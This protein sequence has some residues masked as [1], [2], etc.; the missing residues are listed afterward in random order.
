M[1]PWLVVAAVNGALAVALGAFATH[2]LP[3]KLDPRLFNAFD[4]G[5]RYQMYHALAL[6]LTALAM[7]DGVRGLTK[8]AAICFTAGIVLFS[9]S[10]YAF[11]L[12]E[13][14]AF[15][16]VTP[17]GGVLFLAGWVLLALAAARTEP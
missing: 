12:T 17:V 8:C 15:A 3:G 11:A 16:F 2:A 5:A 7:R 14:R 13:T 1:R 10:L 9:G 4:T 6:G